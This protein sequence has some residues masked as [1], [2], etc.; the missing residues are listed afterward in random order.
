MISKLDLAVIVASIAGTL[1]WMEHAHRIVTDAPTPAERDALA[2]A[3]ACPDNENVPYS[4]TCIDFMQGGNV[5]T[6]LHWRRVRSTERAPAALPDAFTLSNWTRQ[7]AAIA[8][9]FFTT[10]VLGTLATLL[11]LA[12]AAGCLENEAQTRHQAGVR[13]LWILYLPL[14]VPQIAFLFGAQVLLIRAGLDGTL[15]A[16]LWAHLVFVLP[17]VFLSLADPWRALDPR[18]ARSAASARRSRF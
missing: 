4:K 16:T 2:A 17:Y 10:L 13:A 5:A 12:L 7:M 9:P 14:L 3:A 15:L 8:T 18:F 11:A 1:V 6:D